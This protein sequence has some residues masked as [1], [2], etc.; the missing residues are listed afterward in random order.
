MNRAVGLATPLLLTV[1]LAIVSHPVRARGQD[2]FAIRPEAESKDELTKSFAAGKAKEPE[3]IF[4]TNEE[5]QKI[6][7]ADQFMVTRLKATETPYTGKYSRGHFRGTFLC[8]CCGARLFDSRHKFESGTGWPSFYRPVSDRALDT[9]WDYS[10]PEAR[11]EVTC[12]RCGAHLGHVFQD[13]PPPTGLRYCLNSIA[14]KLDNEKAAAAPARKTSRTR[15]AK[16]NNHT[17]ISTQ[18][19]AAR[20]APKASEAATP[21]S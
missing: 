18:N 2:P 3:R 7:T 19:S 1:F 6:L 4:K 14:L 15:S 10:E 21:K 13:G 16:T 9:A 11:V 5:W 12:R 8:V 17:Q 20:P